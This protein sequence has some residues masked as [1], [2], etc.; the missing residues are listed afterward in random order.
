[1][2]KR[3]LCFLTALLL[4]LPGIASPAGVCDHLDPQHW[5]RFS[6]TVNLHG[7][8]Y[9]HPA[10]PECSECPLKNQCAEVAKVPL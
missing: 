2:N 8:Q 9:C 4:V 6:M 7:R 5:G 1:M 3:V 10:K